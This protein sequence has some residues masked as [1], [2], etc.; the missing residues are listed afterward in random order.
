MLP[1]SFL[2]GLMLCASLIVAIGA[3]NAFVLR[4]GL[5]REHVTA[6]VLFCSL[7]DL[8]FISAG[9]AGVAGFLTRLPKAAGTLSVVGAVFLGSY[10]LYA[11]RRAARPRS[12][13]GSAT[14][15]ATSLPTAMTQIAGFTFLNPHVYL[16]TVLLMGSVGAQQPAGQRIGFVGGAA[17]ASCLW[18][19]ALGYGARLLTPLFARARAWQILDSAIALIM[20]ALAVRLGRQ[21]LQG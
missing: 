1:P 17:L 18:F 16:D 2:T 8:L 20:F 7:S 10:G 21:A 19:S 9:V 15:S 11:L 12:L 3:Q 5:R 4:Q 6:I 13:S 14:T